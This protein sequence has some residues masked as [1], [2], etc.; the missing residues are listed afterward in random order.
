MGG[1]PCDDGS[2][3]QSD[4]DQ[5][6]GRDFE[7]HFCV[8]WRPRERQ[9]FNFGRRA[10]LLDFLL[11]VSRVT[12]ETLDLDEQLA[13]IASIVKEVVPYDLF[14]ILLYNEAEKGLKIRY[15]IGHREEI[16]KSLL[17][18][19]NEGIVGAAAS[20]RQPVVVPDVRVDP[21][22]LNALDAV[23]SELAVPL[24]AR[25]KVVGVLDVQSTRANAFTER[26]STMLRLIGSRVAISLD[27]A[28]LL[29]PRSQTEQDV[30]HD[31]G[32]VAGVQLDSGSG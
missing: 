11:E 15:A 16:V 6:R 13:A 10:E 28:R 8:I 17:V 20:G 4:R 29:S 24:V 2:R 25:G 26:E 12:A 32:A 1:L 27:N 30:A 7:G 19:L 21:R 23:R 5:C 9:K 14:A 18:S 3:C 31:D 22:Y